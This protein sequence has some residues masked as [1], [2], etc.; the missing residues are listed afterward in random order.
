MLNFVIAK[1][2]DSYNDVMANQETNRL[3]MMIDLNVETQVISYYWN[4]LRERLWVKQNSKGE[5]KRSYF[6]E[7]QSF[8]LIAPKIPDSETLDVLVK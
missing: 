5:V 1:V 3:N 8:F 2:G 6:R 7:C 4:W